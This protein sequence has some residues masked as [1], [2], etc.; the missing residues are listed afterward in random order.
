MPRT[1]DDYVK[2]VTED[3]IKCLE[4]MKCQPILFVG[5]G[6]SKRYF[7]A[8][9]WEELLIEMANKCPLVEKEFAYY[10]QNAKKDDN[11]NE[12]I[13]IGT[14]FAEFYN[15]WAWN[16]GRFEFPDELFTED[17]P[18]EIYL[19]YKVAEHLESLLKKN[20]INPLEDSDLNEEI[21]LIKKIRPHALI[22]TNYDLLLEKLFSEYEPVVG[23]KI[24]RGNFTNYGEIFKIHGC[25]SDSKG[26][27]LTKNDYDDFEK[28]KKYLSAKLLIFFAEHPLLFIG[29]SAEDPNIK[30][31]LSDIDEIISMHGEVIPNIYILEWNPEI[32]SSKYPV[33][34][35]IISIRGSKN[36][37]IKCI[38]ASSFKWVFDAFA[39]NYN[40][41]NIDVKILR[42]LLA[43]NYE[44]VR[45]DIPRNEL[46]VNYET[47][48][49]VLSG[50]EGLATLYGIA[51][52]D[53]PKYFNAAY[54]YTITQM[55]EKLGFLN[56]KGKISWFKSHK[57]IL[58][59]IEDTG[60][61]I[62]ETDNLYHLK[63]KI[64]TTMSVHK[65]S[66]AAVSLLMK[67]RDNEDYSEDI[68]KL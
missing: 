52:L 54:P 5:S 46:E 11:G 39:A 3:V 20:F 63:V 50:E 10:K 2:D 59:M 1:Y 65:Y 43:R 31:I 32:E 23:Q 55:S 64:G 19:K 8:P 61:N 35:K 9:N 51:L 12:F 42:S 15:K 21:E 66:D 41:K 62:K 18:P 27:V 58:K 17:N 6:L 30:S 7:G 36:I 60:I 44:L 13:D 40:I 4:D 16:E 34:D 25:I 68:S 47:L 37:R 57:L 24:L 29:Y 48:E 53:D 28:K 33:T 14:T 26:I 22:T 56:D 49:H 38:V 45:S 67:I